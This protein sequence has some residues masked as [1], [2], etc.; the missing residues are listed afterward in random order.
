[1]QQKTGVR[2]VINLVNLQL[3]NNLNSTLVRVNIPTTKGKAKKTEVAIM[4]T[5][6]NKNFLVTVENGK[7]VVENKKFSD[8][9]IARIN[10]NGKL[11][12]QSS[13][14]LKYAMN[15]RNEFGF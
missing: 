10:E 7:V 4:K 3:I 12:A 9:Y 15:M 11:V 8:R 1:M 5:Y 2:M 6:E 13:L 14:A